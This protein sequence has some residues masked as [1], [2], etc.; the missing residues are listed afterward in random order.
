[1]ST[2]NQASN[3]TSGNRDKAFVIRVILLVF[4]FA[5][6]IGGTYPKRRQA[7]ENDNNNNYEKQLEQSVAL[8][9]LKY[10]QVA[11]NPSHTEDDLIKARKALI[12]ALWE[13]EEFKEPI[14]LLTQQMGETWGLVRNSYNER[15]A[16][17]CRQLGDLHRDNMGISAAVVCYKSVLDHDRAYLPADDLRIVRDLNNMG[18][19]HYLQGTGMESGEKRNAELKVAQKYLQEA[20]DIMQKKAILNTSR[21]ANTYWNLYL[22][23]RD[24]GDNAAAE[25]NRTKARAIDKSMNR[26]CR[27]P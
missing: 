21:A 2:D 19:I 20:L 15:W 4:V 7:L 24:L 3:S 23:D 17:T 1:M 27:E 10:N 26:L 5:I 22:V 13:K 8:S 6:V 16:D 25:E 9:R 18:I 11:G 12:S 14:A